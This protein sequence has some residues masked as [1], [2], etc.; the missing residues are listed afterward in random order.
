MGQKAKSI[1]FE[2]ITSNFKFATDVSG[3]FSGA[4][5]N[6]KGC[7]GLLLLLACFFYAT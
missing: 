6:Q 3:A 2:P 5:G 4:G 7:R 1:A